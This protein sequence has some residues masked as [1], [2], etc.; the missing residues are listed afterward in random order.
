M[1]L[2]G[3]KGARLLLERERVTTVE[4]GP[5]AMRDFDTPEAFD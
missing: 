5:A 4:I 1:T 3:D 2:D